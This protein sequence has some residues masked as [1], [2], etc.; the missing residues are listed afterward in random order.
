MSARE[1]VRQLNAV[2]CG[3]PISRYTTLHYRIDENPMVLAFVR[4]A[5]ESRPWGI[6]YGRFRDN[7]PTVISVP[8]GRNRIAVS[9]MCEKFAEDLLTYW[10]VEGYSWDPIS[11]DN[12]MS[13]EIPQIWVPSVRHVEMFHHLEYAFWRVRKGDDRTKPL[14]VFA[15]LSGWIYR[16]SNRMGQQAVIDTSK[17][18]RDSFVFPADSSSLMHLGACIEWFKN[19]DSLSEKRLKVRKASSLRDSPT[20]DPEIDNKYLAPLLARR[21]RVLDENKST[22]KIDSE[23]SGILK[24]ELE[25]RWELV[26]EGYRIFSNDN[27]EQNEGTIELTQATIASFCNDYQE[28]EKNI[29]D[30]EL[31]PAYTRHPETDFHGSAAASNYFV[32]AAANTAYLSTLVHFDEELQAEALASGKAFIGEVTHVVD[33]GQ[34]RKTIPIWKMTVEIGETLR[35]RENERYAPLG[36]SKHGVIIRSV[37]VLSE[38]ELEITAE[39][40]DNKT[41]PLEANHLAKVSNEIWVGTRLMFVPK[42]SSSLDKQSSFAVW[43]AA[44]GPGAW[45]THGKAPINAE[46]GIVDDITQLTAGDL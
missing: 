37:E 6:A 31:G 42:D 45:L 27:R 8:D 41:V 18:F 17:F 3:G 23:I 32:M 24:P 33:N 10:R 21:G 39:W 40:N 35:L 13:G 19:A 7:K 1:L 44:S 28:I 2:K 29:K 12:L 26:R 25:R 34:G 15:R 43:Q 36:A 11:T 9:E 14:T 30:P 20:L 4:M 38:N 46:P 22:T 5:G 16:E